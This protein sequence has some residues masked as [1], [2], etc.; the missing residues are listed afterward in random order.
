MIFHHAQRFQW[1]NDNPDYDALPLLEKFRL[2]YLKEVGYVN[3][4]CAWILGCPTEIMPIQ[5]QA[6]GRLDE[7]VTAKRVYKKAFEE[8]FPGEP[9]PEKVGVACCSQFA[10]R[11]ET[12]WQRPREDYVRYREWL[13]SSDLFDDLSGR[14]LE[15]SWHSKISDST[16]IPRIVR[17]NRVLQSSSASRPSTVPT[18]GS[19]IAMPMACATWI[20]NRTNAKASIS[21]RHTQPFPRDG[22]RLAGKARIGSGKE[23]YESCLPFI[24]VRLHA[25]VVCMSIETRT[26]Y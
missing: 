12:V 1:H 3:L 7:P 14:V 2:E 8:L 4:R 25:C 22:R 23:S 19:A 17:A 11:R 9:V 24:R 6:D 26:A 10:V 20:A 5:D 15:Y 13:V 16:F 18:Q 21:S